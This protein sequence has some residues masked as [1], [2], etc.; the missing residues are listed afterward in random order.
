MF[1]VTCSSSRARLRSSSPFLHFSCRN[2]LV[3]ASSDRS[4][5]G[6]FITQYV[7][8]RHEDAQQAISI[9]DL[10]TS[11]HEDAEQAISISDPK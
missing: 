4:R 8:S 2:L 1:Y 10:K 5:R 7:T 11:Q 3:N 6:D 9:S